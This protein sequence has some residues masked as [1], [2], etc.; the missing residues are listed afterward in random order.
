M[1]GMYSARINKNS[2]GILTGTLPETQQMEKL[3]WEHHIKM[4]YG[5]KR[6]RM[7]TLLDWLKVCSNGGLWGSR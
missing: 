6:L 1:L 5:K 3:R 4:D 2:N 7:Q